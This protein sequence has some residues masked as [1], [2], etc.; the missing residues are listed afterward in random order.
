VTKKIQKGLNCYAQK[1]EK[2]GDVG[3]KTT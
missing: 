3:S 2:L 1:V